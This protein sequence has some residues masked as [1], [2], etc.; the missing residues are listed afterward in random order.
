MLAKTLIAPLVAALVAGATIA[1]VVGGS[2]RREAEFA[3]V[4]G[5]VALLA[6]VLLVCGQLQR[7][8]AATRREALSDSLTG[9]GNRRRLF[10]DL[11][12]I[13]G[14]GGRALLALCDLD[15]FK[16]YNDRLGHQAGD[17]LLHALGQ[18]MSLAVDGRGRAYRMG[19]DEFCLLL[20]GAT[21]ASEVE[22]IAQRV[23]G[24]DGDR[25]GVSFSYGVA[26]VGPD[27]DPGDAV[28]LADQRMYRAKATQREEGAV[29]TLPVLSVA[30]G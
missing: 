16:S 9:L 26:D 20:V 24:A 14:Q 22:A 5:V 7:A 6:L 13:Q 3:A 15:G 1:A 29:V 17:E 12:M 25:L 30:S 28:R 2:G 18:R 4:I 19:A 11:A 21:D 23:I 27:A 8:R 10:A